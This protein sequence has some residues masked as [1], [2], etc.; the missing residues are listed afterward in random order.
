MQDRRTLE[1][2]HV[3]HHAEQDRD[4]PADLGGRPKRRSPNSAKTLKPATAERLLSKLTK[5][6]LITSR[7]QDGAFGHH[8]TSAATGRSGL[9][10]RA[11]PVQPQSLQSGV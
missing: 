9:K 10:H 6:G 4:A 7:E 5:E 1:S 11:A 8:L 2:T 3:E